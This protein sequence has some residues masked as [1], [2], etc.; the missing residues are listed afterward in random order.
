MTAK[1]F[2][3][4]GLVALV[5]DGLRR[6]GIAPPEQAPGP[7]LRHT[8]P[9]LVAHDRKRGLLS[10]VMRQHGPVPILRVGEAVADHGFH[11]MLHALLRARGPV[12]LIGRWLRLERYA[13]SH[14]RTAVARLDE[15]GAALRHIS[16]AAEPPSAAEDLLVL[17]VYLG[18][19]RAIGCEG[20][21]AE[22]AGG[23]VARAEGDWDEDAARRAV[24]A[25]DTAAWRLAW[26][27]WQSIRTGVPPAGAPD[28][29]GAP[30]M[31]FDGC[32]EAA[33]VA[34]ILAE[35]PARHFSLA[36]TA[37]RLGLSPRALQRR[38]AAHGLTVT[39]VARA[40]QIRHACAL[41]AGSDE[42]LP[43]IGYVCGFSDQAHF[44]RTF[45][46]RVNMTPGAYRAVQKLHVARAG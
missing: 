5:F 45:R 14:H 8:A 46:K 7:S 17:G 24:A 31:T 15:A 28:P 35:D 10:A 44:T 39:A 27:G 22:V 2:A 34:A 29:H 4:A 1:A 16:T 9:P 36:E 32:A 11:P 3:S 38:L 25:G 37:T 40:V 33:G 23:C 20:V 6:Q 43:A 26:T 13:H 30:A 19:L 42:P 12:D 41:L 18:L 21:S